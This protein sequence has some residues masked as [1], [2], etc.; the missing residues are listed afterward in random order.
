[1]S[2]EIT[3]K[4]CGKRLLMVMFPLYRVKDRVGIRNV[5]QTC[6]HEQIRLASAANPGRRAATQKRYKNRRLEVDRDAFYEERRATQREVYRRRNID[7][8]EAAELLTE[9]GYKRTAELAAKYAVCPSTIRRLIALGEIPCAK[10]GKDWYADE[11]WLREH[12]SKPSKKSER[13]AR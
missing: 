12:L 8:I 6:R 3:C 13:G 7:R 9:K 2:E 1:M 10:V 11:K 5:C 4:K